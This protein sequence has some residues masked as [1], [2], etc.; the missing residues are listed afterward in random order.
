MKKVIDGAEYNTETAEKI[1]EMFYEEPDYDIGSMKK[2]L[3]QLFLTKSGKYF[4]YIVE[5]FKAMVDV[6]NSE[7]LDD[8]RFEEM[9]LMNEKILPVSYDLAFQFVEEVMESNKKVDKKIIEKYFPELVAGSEKKEVKFQKKIYLSNKANWYLQM[10]VNEKE[11]TNSSFIERLII[12]EYRRLYKKG[13]VERDPFH[14][15]GD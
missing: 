4:F 2:T 5:K 9:E 14:E 3:K 1:C 13:I 8:A 15:M 6:N 10:M 12:E 11:D 7:Y